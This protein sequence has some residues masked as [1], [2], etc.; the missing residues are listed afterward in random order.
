MLEN[1][2]SKY[3]KVFLVMR[4]ISLYRANNL[5]Q[6]SKQDIVLKSESLSSQRLR[7]KLFFLRSENGSSKFTAPWI[8]Y[9]RGTEGQWRLFCG[10]HQVL[11]LPVGCPWFWSIPEYLRMIKNKWQSTKPLE[12]TWKGENWLGNRWSIHRTVNMTLAL[13]VL[14][15]SQN[16]NIFLKVA[17]A[18]LS[19]PG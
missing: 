14:G 5:C 4:Y 19:K 17:V 8:N 6:V 18:L 1:H 2:C 15:G 11:W 10:L 12:M 13:P 9:G 3:S 16:Q 7:S